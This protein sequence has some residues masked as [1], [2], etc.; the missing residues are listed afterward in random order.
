LFF[1]CAAVCA[2]ADGA[3]PVHALREY[4]LNDPATRAP[5]EKQAFLDTPLTKQDAQA[6]RTLLWDDHVRMIR[7]T[8]AAEMK[9]RTI[10]DGNLKMPFAYTIFGDKPANGRSLFISMHGGGNAPKALNDQQWEN[11]KRLYKPAEGVYL[12][13]RAPT[14]TWNLWH[15]AHIDRMFDRLIEDLIVFE[16]VDPNRVYLMGYSAGGDGVYQL[17]PR[18]ADRWAAASMMAG[19]PNDAQPLG[20]RDLPFAIHVGAND[21]GFNRNKVAAEWGKKL[22]ALAKADP[23]GYVHV[24]KLHAGKGHWMDREDAEAVPWM[25][26][27]TRNPIP[28]KVAWK[29]STVTHPRFYWLAVEAGDEKAGAEIVAQ[30]KGQEI[31]ID[32]SD[33]ASVK[34]RLDDRMMDLDKPITVRWGDKKVF[35]GKAARTIRVMAQTLSERGD[36]QGVFDSEIDAKR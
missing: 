36:P 33:V 31:T 9:A 26:T 29:Q 11:Q 32:K 34:I 15:E 24:V 3:S 22:D 18:M 30:Y 20:L 5:W 4:L 28:K 8:R 7:A 1:A 14:N 13:P 25:A 16:D 2:H 19:H 12:A 23:G 6:A 21:G 10:T 27:F 35:E 17:A